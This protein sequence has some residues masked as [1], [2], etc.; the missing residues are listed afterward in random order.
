[1]EIAPLIV[2]KEEPD[3]ECDDG[4]EITSE[5][6]PLDHN[7]RIEIKLENEEEEENTV[8]LNP[9]QEVN[10]VIDPLIISQIVLLL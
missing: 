6:A 7:L 10:Q 8:V 2:P 9:C 3:S 1:M 5:N 4:F